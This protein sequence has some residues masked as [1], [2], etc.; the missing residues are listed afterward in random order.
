M[1]HI[2]SSTLVLLCIS[3]MA[4]AQQVYK[5]MG[6]DGVPSYQSDPC[7]EGPARKTWDASEPYVSP[8]EQARIDRQRN[9]AIVAQQQRSSRVQAPIHIGPAVTTQSQQR[10]A[11]CEAAR[12]ER[13][14][15]FEHRGL[16][17]THD[18]LRRWDE[19]VRDRCK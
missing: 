8:A 1:R 17:R 10:R 3:G 2:V 16:R 15:Y 19:Y 14:A 12:R 18:E 9:E 5:C 6:K 7:Q 4:H 11:R 13:D